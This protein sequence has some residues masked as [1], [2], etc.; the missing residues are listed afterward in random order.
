MEEEEFPGP[1]VVLKDTPEERQRKLNESFRQVEHANPVVFQAIISTL[2]IPKA[3]SAD[4]PVPNFKRTGYGEF[5]NYC[6]TTENVWVEDLKDFVQKF[7]SSKRYGDV[8]YC[9]RYYRCKHDGVTKLIEGTMPTLGLSY[10]GAYEL[11]EGGVVYHGW[12]VNAKA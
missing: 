10:F 4:T 1:K 12:K 7:N 6:M 3:E 5:L 9:P 2:K 8:V 11:K